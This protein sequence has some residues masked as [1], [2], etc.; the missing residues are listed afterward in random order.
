MN[1]QSTTSSYRTTTTTTYS[2][3]HVCIR[4]QHVGDVRRSAIDG[5]ADDAKFVD[6]DDAH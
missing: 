6:A 4:T 5:D 1:K 2:Q 3:T